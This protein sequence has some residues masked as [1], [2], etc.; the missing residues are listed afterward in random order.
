MN[1]PGYDAWKLMCPEEEHESR[2]GK[3]CPEC[4]AWHQSQCDM[5]GAGVCAWEESQ[6]D[7]DALMEARRDDRERERDWPE[8]IF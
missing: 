6:P 7:P 3:I 8:D 2:G 1:L 4:G 5:E